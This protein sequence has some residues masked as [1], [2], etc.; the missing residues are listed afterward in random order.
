VTRAWLGVLERGDAAVLVT[1]LS[2]ASGRL[3]VHGTGEVD[4]HLSDTSLERDAIASAAAIGVLTP[5]Q[6]GREKLFVH[7]ALLDLLASD[8]HE[9][10][11]YGLVPEPRLEPAGRGRSA[12]AKEDA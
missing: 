4:G 7:R 5:L 11:A 2:G 3:I 6:A 12:T 1:P 9:P 8:V 10:P